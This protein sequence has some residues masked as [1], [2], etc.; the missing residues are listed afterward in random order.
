[1][2][3]E[4]IDEGHVGDAKASVV[5]RVFAQSEM[6]VQ[7]L[8][9]SLAGGRGNLEAAV[10]VGDTFGARSELLMVGGRPPIA[11]A[12]LGVELRALVVET[13]GHFVADHRADAAIVDRK[14]GL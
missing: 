10:L 5:G 8:R 14:V 9:G 12:A 13:V 7:V 11:Q 1:M 2:R 3:G 6:A 4:S